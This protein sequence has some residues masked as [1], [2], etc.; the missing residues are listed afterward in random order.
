VS[1][2]RS[3]AVNQG[4]TEKRGGVYDGKERVSIVCGCIEPYQ[5]RERENKDF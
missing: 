3:P 2:L 1:T 4:E 5:R